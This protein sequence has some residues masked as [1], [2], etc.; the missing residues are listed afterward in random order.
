MDRWFIS[1]Y[2]LQSIRAIRGGLM[3]VAGICKMDRRRFEV[4][5]KSYISQT[6]IKM[7]EFSKGRV[8][9]SRKFHSKYMTIMAKYSGMDVKLLCLKYKRSEK[10][11]LLLTTDLSLSF[12]KAMELYRIR[13]SIE[14]MFKE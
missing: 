1:D 10:W 6:I 5:E 2:M 14:V 8:H 12:V 7:N 3:H 11:T 9:V 4:N 13:W